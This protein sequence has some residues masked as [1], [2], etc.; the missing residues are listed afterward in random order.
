MVTVFA[1]TDRGIAGDAV[2]EVTAAPLTFIVAFGSAA[3][4]VT[5]KVD[6]AL[7]TLA[8]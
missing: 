6:M 8:V 7:F 3:V 1:P 2:P 5:V 4:G